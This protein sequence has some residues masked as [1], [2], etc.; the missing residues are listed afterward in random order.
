MDIA[1]QSEQKNIKPLLNNEGLKAEDF[2]QLLNSPSIKND[3]I[4]YFRVVTDANRPAIENAMGWLSKKHSPE[5]FSTICK[6]FA[7]GIEYVRDKFGT[8][9][10]LIGIN[11]EHKM[12]PYANA[13]SLSV[14]I[15]RDLL[16][17]MMNSISHRDH[18]YAPFALDSHDAAMMAGVEEAYHVHQIATNPERAKKLL[19]EQTL[20]YNTDNER[21]H[22]AYTLE[23][24]AMQ[25]VRQAMIDK[26]L[27]D[28]YA[29]CMTN[30]LPE[31]V[32]WLPEEYLKK[33]V[34]A[35]NTV[36][37]FTR[38]VITISQDGVVTKSPEPALHPS[39]AK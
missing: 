24:E 16:D 6:G 11:D 28:K 34:F 14:Y 3:P 20:T 31:D 17:A 13:N 27:I 4:A 22:D 26:G 35:A 30:V 9:P 23:H 36:Q 39:H 29:P 10:A 38:G 1:T 8:Q 2:Q 12:F 18:K 7:E 33:R 21:Q 25:V 19:I 37:P 5:E 15:S 32:A